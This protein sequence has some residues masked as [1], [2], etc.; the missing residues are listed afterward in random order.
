MTG[1]IAGRSREE[2]EARVSN[3]SAFGWLSG[4]AFVPEQRSSNFSGSSMA[5]YFGNSLLNFQF[6]TIALVFEMCVTLSLSLDARAVL[7][8]ASVRCVLATS[9]MSLLLPRSLFG[10]LYKLPRT[11]RFHIGHLLCVSLPL[12]L[13]SSL[14][15]LH[16]RSRFFGKFVLVDGWVVLFV[17]F[18]C[19]VCWK[20]HLGIIAPRLWEWHGTNSF[21]CDASH[22]LIL[23]AG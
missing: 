10:N 12:P 5:R 6:A 9:R 11:R 14:C 17:L 23:P 13:A 15:R 16:A 2:E 1:G 18:V 22:A 8:L 19:V 7:F 3:P 20:C 4:L 21:I